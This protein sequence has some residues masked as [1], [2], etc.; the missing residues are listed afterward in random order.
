MT[1]GGWLLLLLLEVDDVG[2]TCCK[3]W[4][5]FVSLSSSL[6]KGDVNV[7]LW[8]QHGRC[9]VMTKLGHNIW[10]WKVKS[11]SHIHT[12]VRGWINLSKINKS[13]DMYIPYLSMDSTLAFS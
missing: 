2:R 9:R 6:S 12:D 10:W 1:V 8:E 7:G 3:R 5:V 13:Y 11:T 4:Y